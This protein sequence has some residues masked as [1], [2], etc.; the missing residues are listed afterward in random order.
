V[1]ILPALIRSRVDLS[2]TEFRFNL[3]VAAVH[4]GAFSPAWELVLDGA[5][6]PLAAGVSFC[7]S[8]RSDTPRSP[9][10]SL[11]AEWSVLCTV[12]AL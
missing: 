8:W 5:T 6:I 7:S 9:S 11:E 12:E 2:P 10:V 4:W 3:R 1:H